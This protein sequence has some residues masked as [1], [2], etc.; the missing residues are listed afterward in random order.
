MHQQRIEGLF[1]LSGFKEMEDNYNGRNFGV[2]LNDSYWWNY[3]GK[4]VFFLK[5][6]GTEL[7][8]YVISDTWE[9]VRSIDRLQE[10]IP[11]PLVKAIT[12]ELNETEL[13]K[14]IVRSTDSA[15]LYEMDIADNWNDRIVEYAARELCFRYRLDY[16]QFDSYEMLESAVYC[17]IDGDL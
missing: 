4:T 10:L 6:S 9:K 16:N 11:H 1:L 12:D 15:L 5:E 17:L 3:D 7:A 14:L 2:Y 13:K 8:P